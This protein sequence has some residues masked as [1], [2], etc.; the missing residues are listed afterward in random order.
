[1]GFDLEEVLNDLFPDSNLSQNAGSN[2]AVQIGINGNVVTLD[3]YVHIQGDTDVRIDRQCVVDL[4][5]EGIQEWSGVHLGPFGEVI[6]VDINVHQVNARVIAY[7]SQSYI[8]VNII[9]G[10]GVSNLTPPSGGWSPRTPGTI[11]LFT[12]FSN[13]YD[14]D[15]NLIQ[16]GEARTSWQFVNLSTHE[17]GHG[18]GV[19][20]GNAEWREDKPPRPAADMMI[21]FY[22]EIMGRG[23][24]RA[25]G[26]I[27]R[28]SIQMMIYAIMSGDWQRFMEYER[29]PQSITLDAS[30]P[31]NRAMGG[32]L[33]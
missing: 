24:H 11:N 3:V 27:S 19:N 30:L 5:I 20:D 7:G 9:D 16:L 14:D 15:G 28:H 18:F 22:F 2:D 25:D 26:Y 12:H 17:F 31:K 4:T 23:M 32:E 8:P 21:L 1:M 29:G 10:P 13:D 6:A 33:G